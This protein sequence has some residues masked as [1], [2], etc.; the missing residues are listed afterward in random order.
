MKFTQRFGVDGA[1]SPKIKQ[2]L[3]CFRNIPSEFTNDNELRKIK[4][5]GVLQKF[6]VA[7]P[8][9]T[10]SN[11]VAPKL[12]ARVTEGIPS[13]CAKF[14]SKRLKITGD[15]KNNDGSETSCCAQGQMMKCY[16]VFNARK[17]LSC[18]IHT[19]MSALYGAQNVI[20]KSTVN[21]CPHNFLGEWQFLDEEHL[22]KSV[23]NF[24]E[25][26]S[27]WYVTDIKKLF[28]QYEK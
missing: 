5:R 3:Y 22:K 4:L 23:I 1:T 15:K 18:E 27:A 26:D 16:S 21:R 19:R 14:Y 25:K 11:T 17:W 10:R 7:Q 24:L 12:H 2:V 20:T 6:C 13:I 9:F 8:F 28:D